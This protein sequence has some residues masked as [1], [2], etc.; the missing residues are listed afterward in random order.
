MSKVYENSAAE[1]YG[2]R[3]GDII[4]AIDGE[5][6][7]TTECLFA[8]CSEKQPGTSWRLPFGAGAGRESLE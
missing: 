6:C 2:L 5:P 1:R 3:E 7:K 4:V 8:A